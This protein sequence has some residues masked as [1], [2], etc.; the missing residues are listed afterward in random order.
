M[1]DL[2]PKLRELVDRQE[3]LDCLHRYTRGMD[4]LDRE[5]A[6]SA[7]HDGA[8]DVHR[9]VVKEV[10]D[11]LDWAFAYHA[12]QTL[13]QHYIG[14]NTIEIDGDTAHAETYYTF[15]GRYPDREAPLD[16]AGG[17]YIDRFE[18]RDGR[19][20]IAARVCTLEWMMRP[21]S[22]VGGRAVDDDALTGGFTVARNPTDVS[23]QRPMRV[24]IESER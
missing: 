19:W 22:A 3:I 2:A 8:I 10:D 20:A 9:D 18:R 1:D 5:L 14:N 15:V 13:H 16:I 11:F 23:Y 12:T 24:R 4:R 21:D 6:R 17:R 7:Y